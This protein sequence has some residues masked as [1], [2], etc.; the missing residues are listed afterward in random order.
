MFPKWLA[1]L[2]FS[3]PLQLPQ[4]PR[5]VVHSEQRKCGTHTSAQD[6]DRE[7]GLQCCVSIVFLNTVLVSRVSATVKSWRRLLRSEKS[8]FS[9]SL[10]WRLGDPINFDFLWGAAHYRSKDESKTYQWPEIEWGCFW[11]PKGPFTGTPS[12]TATLSTRL[13][14]LK[15]LGTCRY[16]YPGHE[17]FA[18]GPLG[19]TH[20]APKP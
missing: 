17:A 10:F 9:D 2:G 7:L 3:K 13:Y 18:H 14:F 19:S 16:H 6:K 11:V 8:F 5:T 12:V 4:E 20:I 15:A 1:T